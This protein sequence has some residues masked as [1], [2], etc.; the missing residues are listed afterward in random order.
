MPAR[1]NEILTPRQ[2]Y[3]RHGAH[4]LFGFADDT[5]KRLETRTASKLTR[6]VWV[7]EIRECLELLELHLAKTK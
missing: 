4:W 5:L 7:S 3:A 6:D 2:G 1:M